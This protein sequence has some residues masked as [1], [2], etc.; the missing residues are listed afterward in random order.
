MHKQ[1]RDL[2]V[3]QIKKGAEKHPILLHLLIKLLSI[4]VWS[5][6]VYSRWYISGKAAAYFAIK[7]IL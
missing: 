5:A 6:A 7:H 3:R 1:Q 2:P 4:T